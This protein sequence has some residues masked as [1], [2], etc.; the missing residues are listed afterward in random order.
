MF[1]NYLSIVLLL[2][3]TTSPTSAQDFNAVRDDQINRL[4]NYVLTA[5]RP[6]GLVRDSI[7]LNNPDF[8]FHPAT[9]DAAGFALLAAQRAKS[10]R[11]AAGCRTARGECSISVCRPERLE[12]CRI[13]L[14]TVISSIP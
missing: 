8:S 12:S 4:K 9:P 5:I 10:R 14:R 1:R 13:A 11:Q 2:F 3:L 6:N 7:V